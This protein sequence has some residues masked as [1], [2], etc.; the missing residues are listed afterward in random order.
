[1]RALQIGSGKGFLAVQAIL[2]ISF[3][4]LMGPSG[5]ESL[6]IQGTVINRISDVQAV[7]KVREW[8]QGEED[9]LDRFR[10]GGGSASRPHYYTGTVVF[11]IIIFFSLLVFAMKNLG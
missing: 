4:F 1:M 9:Y 7:L 3:L 2:I 6:E 11:L 8:E 5:S 10:I